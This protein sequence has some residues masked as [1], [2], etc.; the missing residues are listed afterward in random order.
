MRV[1]ETIIPTHQ[2]AWKN[3]KDGLKYHVGRRDISSLQLI[4]LIANIFLFPMIPDL[5]VPI[6]AKDVLQIGA[7]GYGWLMA[8]FS[9]GLLIGSF[10][11]LA[12]ANFRRKG[13]LAAVDSLLWG[14]TLWLFSNST[15]YPLS[16]LMMFAFGVMMMISMALIEVLLLTNSPPEMRGRVMGIRM[17]VITCEFIS[18]LIWGVAL[19]LISAPLAGQINS[20]LFTLS[21][22]GIIVWAPSL[23]KM[24]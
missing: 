9:L 4:A 7:S 12:L 13:L 5:L 16:L 8:A 14:P 11:I 20:V 18:N 10:C 22:I 17:Q 3:L 21:M 6:V 19:G 24:E 2:S 23:K 15:W 1:S